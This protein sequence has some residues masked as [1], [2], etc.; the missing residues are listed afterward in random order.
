MRP[1]RH[2]T[3][4]EFVRYSVEHFGTPEAF[5]SNPEAYRRDVAGKWARA[6]TRSNHKARNARRVH[7][8]A[9]GLSNAQ[10]VTYAAM[11]E[12]LSSLRDRRS[13]ALREAGWHNSKAAEFLEAGDVEKAAAYNERSR[14]SLDKADAL[15]AEWNALYVEAEAIVQRL[16][17][18]TCADLRALLDSLETDERDNSSRC[19][20]AENFAPVVRPPRTRATFAHAPP[21]RNGK[22]LSGSPGRGVALI[23][24]TTQES[25]TG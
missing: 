16:P 2:S 19:H 23:H 5:T 6:A 20:R 1:H 13:S 10:A 18:E 11:L 24:S 15:D 22:P 7:L 12:E 4:A 3:A 17:N 8:R 9:I 21:T 14:R 25:E